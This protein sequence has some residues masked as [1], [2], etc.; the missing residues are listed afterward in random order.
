[1]ADFPILYTLDARGKVCTWAVFTR[2]SYVY[3]KFGTE[4]GEQTLSSYQAIGKNLGKSNATTSEE[5][6]DKEALALWEGKKKRKYKEDREAVFLSTYKPMLAKKYNPDKPPRMPLIVQP[7]LDGVRALSYL[8]RGKRVL[9]GRSGLPIELPHIKAAVSRLPKNLILDGE[10]YLH[11]MSF[12][13]ITKLLKTPQEDTTKLEYHLFDC[14]DENHQDE[15]YSERRLHLPASTRLPK[16]SPIKIV[17]CTTVRNRDELDNAQQQYLNLLYEG[18]IIRVPSGIYRFGYRSSDLLKYKE[19]LDD[20]FKVVGWETGK[21]KFED[22]VIWICE[23]SNG[24]EFRAT[25]KGTT[26]ERRE[27]L[28]TAGDYIGQ[29]LTVRYFSITE[30]GIPRFPVGIGFRLDQDQG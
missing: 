22:C 20:E 19:F 10:I 2:G 3:T 21:G 27:Y 7:K 15:P 24:K 23:T 28:A 18:V 25:Q 14:I 26:E 1:M 16:N 9:I 13:Q 4:D 29:A 12:Q 17:D 30:D 11:G 8:K 6:A 5:Q